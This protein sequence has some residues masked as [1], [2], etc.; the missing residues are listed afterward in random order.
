MASLSNAMRSAANIVQGDN[1]ANK[2]STSGSP[3]VDA[4]TLMLQATTKAE[5]TSHVNNIISE[6]RNTSTADRNIILHDLFVLAFHKRATSKNDS[7]NTLISDG[8]GFRDVFYHYILELYN[9]FPNTV[10]DLMRSGIFSLYGYWKDYIN[11]W[12]MINELSMSD[13]ARYDKYNPMIEA[14]REVFLTQ[15]TQDIKNLR[16]FGSTNGYDFKNGNSESFMTFMNSNRA[17]FTSDYAL[18]WV[19]KYCVRESSPIN[20]TCFWYV[21]RGGK[22]IREDHVSYMVRHLLVQTTS[23]GSQAYP[24]S[25]TVP[26]GAKKV[27]RK[28]NSYLNV[29]LDVPEVKF[30]CGQWANLNMSRIPSVCLH[31]NKK[32]LLNEKR[33]VVPSTYEQE[34]GNRFPDNEDRVDCRQN[35]M[36]HILSGK[37]VNASQLLPNQIVGDPMKPGSIMEQ[38]INE[39]T[40]SELLRLT[41]EKMD[42]MKT[43]I[44]EEARAKGFDRTVELALSSGNILCCCDTSA[45]MTW[46]NK[47]PNRPYDIGVALTAFCSSLAG[48]HYK[49]LI[50]TFSTTP[51]IVSLRDNGGQPLPLY[52]RISKI[53]SSGNSGSTNYV[54][55]HEALISLCVKN[56]IPAEERPVTVIFTDGEF[57][58]MMGI[59]FI[60]RD[61]TTIHDRV[62]KLWVDAGYPGP[63]VICYWNVAPN[64]NGVQTE[65]DKSGV[66]FLQGPAPSNIKYLIYGETADEITKEVIIDGQKVTV[67]T[68]DI[69]PM[70]VFRKAMDQ[71]YFAPVREI[72]ENSEE[73]SF[74]LY[75]LYE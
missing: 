25:K 53:N 9:H 45:S 30:C 29:A 55:M 26:F 70:Q 61:F 39:A 1:G 33:K 71:S 66:I 69:D 56:N 64:R 50:M 31:R 27:W 24:H 42:N 35:V 52:E 4:F 65:A 46:I 5:V 23:Q 38:K 15:R 48:E 47:V 19:G 36:D 11:L 34:T 37:K 28:E 6:Y 43:Q 10:I 32:G 74:A 22:L 8:E 59:R 72:L 62:V 49:D 18:T 68:K 20:K 3:R 75:S 7:D 73:G 60:D 17:Q 67:T 63:P 51:S 58:N 21:S 12:K 40:W 44:L 54:G 14:I 13:Q 2:L 41:R 16:R 57:N